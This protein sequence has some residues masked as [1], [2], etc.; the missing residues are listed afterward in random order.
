MTKSKI[1]QYNNCPYAFYVKYVTKWKPEVMSPELKKGIEIHDEIDKAVKLSTISDEFI[2]YIRNSELYKTWKNHFD[3]VSKFQEWTPLPIGHELN[4]EDP[5]I[6]FGGI[7]D[8]VQKMPNGDVILLDYKTGKEVF[9]RTQSSPNLFDTILFI[10]EASYLDDNLKS[11]IML[12]I[13]T[14]SKVVYIGDKDQL[15]AVGSSTAPAL[16]LPNSTHLQTTSR[17]KPNSNITALAHAFRETLYGSPWPNIKDY[18]DHEVHLLNESQLHNVAESLFTSHDYFKN[19]NHVKLLAWTN[20]SVIGYNQE[21]RKII[22]DTESDEFLVGEVVVT[23]DPVINAKGA[24]VATAGT[25]LTIHSVVDDVSDMFSEDIPYTRYTTSSYG[26]TIYLSFPKNRKQVEK[27]SQA[28]AK[29]QNWREY[30]AL[31][32]TFHDARSY[33]AITVHKAQGSTFTN[34]LIDLADI[35]KNQKADE[36]ARLLYVACSRPTTNLYL[37]GELPKKYRG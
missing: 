15:L 37:F 9:S 13:K 30:F 7:I 22:L 21:C 36:V 3:N 8:R 6:N 35:G 17:Q 27:L 4:L 18:L 19:P 14:G 24:M 1:G 34:V 31:K 10:D 29:E 25:P 2:R 12:S 26:S 11:K 28:Y 32:D 33:H 20:D 16:E 5:N 23:N